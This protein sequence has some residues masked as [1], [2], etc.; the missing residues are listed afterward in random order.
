MNIAIDVDGVLTD[1]EWFLDYYALKD[2]KVSSINITEFDLEKRYNWSKNQVA[3]FHR[4]HFLWY[5]VN[6]PIRENAAVIIRELKKQGNRIYII[7]ARAYAFEKSFIG[8]I[9]RK[10]L[11]RWL[12]KN[13]VEYDEIHFVDTHNAAVE[14]RRLIKELKIDCFIEDDPRNINAIKEHCKV[15]CLK[16]RYNSNLNDV[17]YALNFFDVYAQINQINNLEIEYYRKIPFDKKEFE[18]CANY[19]KMVINSIGKVLELFLDITI[20]NINNIP[21]YNGVI[22]VINHRRS[23]DIPLAY[24]ILKKKFVRFL[25]KK[26]YELSPLRFIQKPLGT[27][28]VDRNNKISG[29]TSR[30]IMLQTLLNDGNVVLFPEGTRNETKELLLPFHY[31]AV[32]I[33]QITNSPIVPIVINK[34]GMLSYEIQVG[35][36][37]AVNSL[38]DITQKNNELRNIMKTMLINMDNNTYNRNHF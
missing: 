17:L 30:I 9:M 21:E 16:T 14:K 37:F 6:M 18:R 22:F 24:L 23:M 5:I 38:D 13:S 10:V 33:A 20:E 1:Y 4:R 36:S 29:K 11:K 31:G 34:V 12:N 3:D 15:I 2:Y 8:Y 28:Y 35:T 25:A 27:I 32:K 26:E 19:H 7:T